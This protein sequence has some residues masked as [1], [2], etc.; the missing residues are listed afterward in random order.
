MFQIKKVTEKS[1]ARSSA[2]SWPIKT[3]GFPETGWSVLLRGGPIIA[4][5]FLLVYFSLASPHF[6]TL[7]NLKNINMKK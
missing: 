5:L 2:I 6:G 7:S 1:D 4:L 3:I